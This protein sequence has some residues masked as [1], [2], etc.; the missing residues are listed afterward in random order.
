MAI[1]KR[2]NRDGRT[3]YKVR[4][5]QARRPVVNRTFDKLSDAKTFELECRLKIQKGESLAQ[6]KTSLVDEPLR[7]IL[8]KY[9][10]E[11]TPQKRSGLARYR[12]LVRNLCNHRIADTPLSSIAPADVIAYRDSRLKAVS[13]KTVRNELAFLSAVFSTALR[14]WG[15][16]G[17]DNPVSR[18]RKPKAGRP[19]DRRLQP[20]EE[21]KLLSACKQYAD[22]MIYEI[23]VL[24]LETAMRRGEIANLLW[25]HV[26]LRKRTVH[27]PETKT[28]EP[29]TVPLSSRA[30][31]VLE[32]LPRRIDG[33][34]FGLTSDAIGR[35]FRRVCARAGIEGLRF[36]D[37]RHEATSRLFEKGLNPMQVAAITGHK[38]LQMLKRY[39]HLRAEDLAELL[40]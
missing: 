13:E 26:N 39:T 11:I 37:L 5:W 27:L 36:H 18:I 19:R 2:K 28:G 16:E 20:G 38:T 15:M 14:D 35:A 3:V 22:G 23:V 6:R 10:D 30:A 9:L 32:R 34:V 7:V 21:E 25:E 33:R 29:R 17:L 40:G 31:A 24:A 8:E 12:S 1:E 4:I